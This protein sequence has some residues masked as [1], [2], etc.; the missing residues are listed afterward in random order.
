MSQHKSDGKFV[1]I[2][3]GQRVPGL[4][5]TSKDAEDEA[6]RQRQISETQGGQ[7]KAAK[8]DVKRN[9]CG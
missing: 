3:N 1:V 4:H 2:K 9:L 6:K 5:E 8:V 7:G